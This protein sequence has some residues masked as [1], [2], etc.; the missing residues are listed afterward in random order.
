MF[1]TISFCN[2]RNKI[3]GFLFS[4]LHRTPP[5]S[6]FFKQAKEERLAQIELAAQ[7]AREEALKA[8][9]EQEQQGML[10]PADDGFTVWVV[11]DTSAAEPWAEN[12][13][14]IGD[15][16]SVDDKGYLDVARKQSMVPQD[17]TT[18]TSPD[19]LDVA[20]KSPKSPEYLDILE[21]QRQSLAEI[22]DSPI[23]TPGYP[24]LPPSPTSIYN[25]EDQTFFPIEKQ[26]SLVVEGKLPYE[27]S[28]E[29]AAT[30]VEEVIFVVQAGSAQ[31][32]DDSSDF[33]ADFVV[34]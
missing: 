7:R 3:N 18:P 19:Y 10:V 6:S 20:Q 22:I 12:P 30:C 33:L 23:L 32:F 27:L 2:Y 11:D 26:K 29:A 9:L 13:Y 1:E 4:V 14:D 34:Q 15:D 31:D 17:T 28:P 25:P 21:K 5:H 8:Q 16:K 24:T